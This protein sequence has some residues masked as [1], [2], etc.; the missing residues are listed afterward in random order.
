MSTVDVSTPQ[1]K[2][3]ESANETPMTAKSSGKTRKQKR[4]DKGPYTKPQLSSGDKTSNPRSSTNSVSKEVRG[5]SVYVEIFSDGKWCPRAADKKDVLVIEDGAGTA[6]NAKAYELLM[7][8]FNVYM[9]CAG[10][11]SFVYPPKWE[12][13]TFDCKKQDLSGFGEDVGKMIQRG[14][15]LPSVIISG[16]R[17]GQIAMNVLLRK[18]WR[19]PFVCLNAGVLTSK[20]SIPPSAFGTFLTFGKDNFPTHD[21]KFTSST[22]QS[23]SQ[24]GQHC[25]IVHFQ[26]V[27]HQP[28][29]PVLISVM[30]HAVCCAQSKG[31]DTVVKNTKWPNNCVV[32]KVTH[33]DPQNV[34]SDYVHELFRG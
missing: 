21:V 13:G 29:T 18:F 22:F 32:Y 3:E 14:E 33:H 28:T 31:D 30:K 24:E 4:N 20:T 5:E 12:Q 26:E 23:L 8:D 16:S 9:V 2:Q 34:T 15:I 19:G 7:E 27:G 6:R 10:R 11:R 25:L 1:M 17:G